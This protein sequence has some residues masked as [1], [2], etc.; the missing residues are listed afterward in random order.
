MRDRVRSIVTASGSTVPATLAGR[1]P[2]SGQRRRLRPWGET[3]EASRANLA[4]AI[5]LDGNG[6]TSRQAE[7]ER[8]EIDV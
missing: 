1:D 2:G 6:R 3:S 5:A 8:A 4:H 7:Q